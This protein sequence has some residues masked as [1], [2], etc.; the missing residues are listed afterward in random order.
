MFYCVR[1]HVSV[2]TGPSS[3]V[4]TNQVNKC[5]LHVGIPTMFTINISILYL[6]DKYINSKDEIMIAYFLK[7]CLY[8]KCHIC[9]KI[10]N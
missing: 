1:L 10:I 3:G 6:V 7:L 4:V 9:G 5:W 8:T 2:L